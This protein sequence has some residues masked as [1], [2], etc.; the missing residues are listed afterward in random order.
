MLGPG[1]RSKRFGGLSGGISVAVRREAA[2]K[3]V[4]VPV[5]PAIG[6][7]DSFRQSQDHFVEIHRG[8]EIHGLMNVIR[9]RVIPL[10][11]PLLGR[12]FFGRPFFVADLES[13]RRHAFADEIVL[14]AAYE[15]I[16]LRLLVPLNPYPHRSATI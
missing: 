8:F 1:P 10:L 15:N 3:A 12:S 13:Q 9:R 2:E 7:G 6:I 16:S 11:Q 4:V 14:I 5:W